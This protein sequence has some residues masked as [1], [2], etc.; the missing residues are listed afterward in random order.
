MDALID[1]KQQD[2]GEKVSKERDCEIY[3]MS[4][5]SIT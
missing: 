4:F 5:D 3:C 2:I 1:K